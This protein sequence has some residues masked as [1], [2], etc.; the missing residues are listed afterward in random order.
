MQN[1]IYKKEKCEDHLFPRLL[2]I[3]ST[4]SVVVS[5]VDCITL[6]HVVNQLFCILLSSPQEEPIASCIQS[7][8]V[9]RKSTTVE[10]AQQALLRE[11][12][13]WALSLIA[14]ESLP[15]FT[16]TFQALL[17]KARDLVSQLSSS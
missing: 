16:E 15:G 10:C 17:L 9:L 5:T 8:S 4:A 1:N 13:V 7:G 6:Y 11:T 12:M 2:I 14:L 3:C